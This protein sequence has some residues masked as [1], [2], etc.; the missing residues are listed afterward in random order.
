MR[1]YWKRIAACLAVLVMLGTG[2]AMILPAATMENGQTAESVELSGDWGEDLAAVAQSQIG[3]TESST[4]TVVNDVGETCGSTRYGEWY[5]DE[6]GDWNG[7]FL[8]FCLHYA[9]IPEDAVKA[10]ADT[11]EMLRSA[12]EKGFYEE[13]GVY[14]PEVGDI[15]FLPDDQAGIVTEVSE[16]GV[17]VTAGDIDGAVAVIEQAQPLGYGSMEEARALYDGTDTDSQ[18]VDEGEESTSGQNSSPAD[19][20]TVGDGIQTS[21][22]ES[23]AGTQADQES[24]S[25]GDDVQIPDN[26]AEEKS[27][28]TGTENDVVIQNTETNLE[29]Y[30]L[31]RGFANE[32]AQFVETL[33]DANGQEVEREN[34]K[35]QVYPGENYTWSISLYAPLGIPDA[36]IYYYNMPEGIT[37]SDISPENVTADDGTVIGTL[38]VADGAKVVVRMDDNTKIRV[39]IYFEISVFFEEGDDGKPLSPIIEYIERKDDSE[40]EIEKTHILNSEGNFE[41]TITARIPGY[42]GTGKYTSWYIRDNADNGFPYQPDLSSGTV[43]ISYGGESYEL[44]SVT[45]AGPE[46]DIAYWWGTDVRGNRILGFVTRRTSHSSSD[47]QSFEGLDEDW[48]ADWI[49][50]EDAVI[51]VKYI[52]Q[53]IKGVRLQDSFENVARLHKD[54]KEVEKA[55]DIFY[56]PPVIGKEYTDGQFVIT[57]NEAEWDLSGLEPVVVN[58]SMQGSIFYRLGSINVTASNTVTG[59]D[60]EQHIIEQT[61]MQGADR[62][63]TLDVSDDLKTLT[64]TILHPGAYKY[65]ITY[66]VTTTAA[67]TGDSSGVEYENT[68]SVEIFGRKFDTEDSGTISNAGSSAEEYVVSIRKTD[69][70]LHEAVPGAVYGLYSSHGELLARETTGTDGTV[71]FKGDPS[72]GFML[73]SNQL[74]YFEEI[75]APEGYQ[76]SNERYWFY[77]SDSDGGINNDGI[78]GDTDN[79]LIDILL[80]TAK[81]EGY[82]R[83]GEDIVE[84]KN[85]GYINEDSGESSAVPIEVQDQLIDLVR[86]SRDRFHGN[87]D[88]YNCRFAVDRQRCHCFV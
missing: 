12:Q 76:L 44:P 37:A 67:G 39:R 79:D 66:D 27:E 2:Y 26:E 23:D 78:D 32:E 52:D 54:G 77:Y 48:C 28:L 4:D 57:F 82:Y 50:T 60:G 46:D 73:S 20:T 56:I 25:D 42:S 41:W 65:Q 5:G 87:K 85:K 62:D 6:Y 40:G 31:T 58:D 88:V 24:G 86:T 55:Q 38:E 8:A 68:A 63:Y 70:D 36:G 19:E 47:H 75:T 29:E 15:A 69:V 45:E 64:I 21:P 51:T 7:M 43:T 18:P 11:A 72:A 81:V 35:Y 33:L 34:G 49:L 74:Y 59:A 10:D 22:G 80:E 1:R 84:V 13:A 17:S 53:S 61:L 30:V 71:Q 9:E 14:Q 16:E 3:Y 83:D